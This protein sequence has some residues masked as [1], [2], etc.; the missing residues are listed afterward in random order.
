[1]WAPPRLKRREREEKLI[2]KKKGGTPR[3]HTFN[4]RHV[5]EKP[6][7]EKTKAGL[8]K[9]L[10]LPKKSPPKGENAFFLQVRQLFERPPQC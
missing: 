9:R 5:V 3:G 7:P 1:M 4:P 2:A 10:S 8:K 6:S